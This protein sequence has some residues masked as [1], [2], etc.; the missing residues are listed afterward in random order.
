MLY[1]M[2]GQG[3]EA[4][5][6]LLSMIPFL[7]GAIKPLSKGA[8]KGITGA[9]KKGGHGL[10]PSTDTAETAVQNVEDFYQGTKGKGGFFEDLIS[11]LFE[12]VSKIDF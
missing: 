10:F 12:D 11:N 1:G 2:Q 4:G 9:A 5:F 7:G 3:R 8:A 6:S